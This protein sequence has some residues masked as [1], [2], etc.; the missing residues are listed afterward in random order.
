MMR[1]ADKDGAHFAILL[2]EQELHTSTATIKNMRT[3]AQETVKQTEIV[4]YIK[5]NR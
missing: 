5:N 3:G 4:A 2:G 1:S